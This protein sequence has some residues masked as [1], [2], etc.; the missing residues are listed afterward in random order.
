MSTINPIIYFPIF[1]LDP[2][3][4]VILCY[5]I[6]PTFKNTEVTLTYER[7]VVALENRTG[8][9]KGETRNDRGDYLSGV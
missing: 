6:L 8:I 4:Y 5:L 2:F 9:M 1:L 7:G 3:S